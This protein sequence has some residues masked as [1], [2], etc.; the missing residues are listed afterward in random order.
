[1]KFLRC[2]DIGKEKPAA[3]DKNEKIDSKKEQREQLGATS[4]L[5]LCILGGPAY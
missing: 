3:L 2:G 5:A 4:V 1:M